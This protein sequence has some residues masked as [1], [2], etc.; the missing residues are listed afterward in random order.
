MVGY[1]AFVCLLLA[2]TDTLDSTVHD[3]TLVRQN[4]LLVAIARRESKL[5]LIIF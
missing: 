2:T 1:H 5:E 4:H 3:W